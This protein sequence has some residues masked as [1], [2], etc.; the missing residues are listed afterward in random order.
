MT[1][2]ARAERISAILI[3]GVFGFEDLERIGFFRLD[4]LTRAIHAAPCDG[5]GYIV[6]RHCKAI[7]TLIEIHVDPLIVFVLVTSIIIGGQS[8]AYDVSFV[9]A[10]IGDALDL[11]LD[12]VNRNCQLS[13]YIVVQIFPVLFKSEV[14]AADCPLCTFDLQAG[15]LASAVLLSRL[16]FQHSFCLHWLQM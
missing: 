10:C 8:T 12:T 4:F 7:V 11:I 15:V 6:I 2:A 13:G 3:L 1:A 9:D 5:D 14:F 16:Q